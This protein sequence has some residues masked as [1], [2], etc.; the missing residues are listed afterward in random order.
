[1]LACF[2]GQVFEAYYVHNNPVTAL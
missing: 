2:E 1:L